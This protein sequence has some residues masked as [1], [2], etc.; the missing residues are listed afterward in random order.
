[1]IHIYFFLA[2]HAV[3]AYCLFNVS[4]VTTRKHLLWG[5]DGGGK[6]LIYSVNHIYLYQFMRSKY[7]PDCCL[8]ILP[9]LHLFGMIFNHLI[10][11]VLCIKCYF[12]LWYLS[13]F[14]DCIIVCSLTCFSLHWSLVIICIPDK[15]DESGLTIFHL[16]SLGLHP[17]RSIFNN[18]KRWD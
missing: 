1:M 16:D 4:R 7:F 12:R 13:M 3:S 17:T 10:L 14:F 6:V 5:W 11:W 8:L 15:E 9:W 2:T 18:V